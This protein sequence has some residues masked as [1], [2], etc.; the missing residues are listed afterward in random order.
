MGLKMMQIIRKKRERINI[1]YES[2]NE[3]LE[4]NPERVGPLMNYLIPCLDP[5]LTKEKSKDYEVMETR[6]LQ[7]EDVIFN[8]PDEQLTSE[9]FGRHWPIQYSFYP[10][11]EIAKKLVLRM[12]QIKKPDRDLWQAFVPEDKVREDAEFIHY[13]QKDVLFWYELSEF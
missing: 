9:F 5:D 4:T 7:Q 3:I 6:F 13:T 11:D 10:S 12:A 8:T 1:K 2:I